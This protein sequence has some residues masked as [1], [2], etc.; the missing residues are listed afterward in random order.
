MVDNVNYNVLV[1]FVNQFE[2]R[3]DTPLINS[4]FT[5]M[6]HYRVTIRESINA[7]ELGLNAMHV[8]CLYIIND[9]ENCTANDIVQKMRRDKAQIARLIKELINLGLVEKTAS[10]KDKRCFIISFTTEGKALLTKVLEAEKAINE[11][12][13][14]NI[15]EEQVNTFTNVIDK[16]NNNLK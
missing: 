7:N 11:K 13:C 3:M 6:Q 14:K 12:M 8:R 16:M 2:A 1:D 5:L 15:S 9:I 4:L 10:I